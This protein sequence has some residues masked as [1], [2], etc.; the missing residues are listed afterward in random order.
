MHL[1]APIWWGKCFFR[2]C[3]RLAWAHNGWG[4]AGNGDAGVLEYWEQGCRKRR[5]RRERSYAGKIT[6]CCAKVREVSRKFAQIRPVIT[7]LFGFSR[8]RP[9]FR[10][11]GECGE[12][13]VEIACRVKLAAD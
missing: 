9:F 7:R 1:S 2:R 11:A 6:G 12:M 5:A 8:V 4:D 3:G 10:G 13:A